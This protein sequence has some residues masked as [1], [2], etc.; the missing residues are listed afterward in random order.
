ML[1]LTG[2]LLGGMLA[3]PTPT[4]PDPA[5]AKR[6]DA[7]L[8]T[9]VAE[10]RIVG[11]VVLVAR[12]GQVVYRRAVGQ[13]D[14]EAGTPMTPDT[15]FR[16][17]SM[18]KP[19]V[20]L[21]ALRLAEQGKLELQA[22]VT[23]YLPWF[24]PRLADGTAPAIT[25]AQLL[26]HS[27]GL[28]YRFE[29]P[30]DGVYARLGISDGLDDAG[31]GLED[32][33]KRLAQA[34]L[35]FPPGQGWRYSLG[36]DVIGAVIEQATGKPLPEAV[37][38]LV[39]GP[40]RLDYLAFVAAPGTPLAVPYADGHPPLR[41]TENMDVPLPEGLGS[42]VRFSPRRAFDAKAFPSGGA[43]MIGTADDYLRLLE[44]VRTGGGGLLKPAT[45]ADARRDQVGAQAQTQGPGW[46]F[47]YGWAVLDDPAAAH[48]PQG[49]GT[50]QWGGAYG[51]NWFVDPAN[52]LSV[53]LLT[54]TAFEGMYG[55]LV[56]QVR[57][58]VY[59]RTVPSSQP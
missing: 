58:A 43:G 38:A 6:L 18:T 40:L 47:G 16:L 4:S 51:H 12:D 36:I 10:Q 2:L 24:R 31:L 55:P 39:T 22:P 34:P 33:L 29:E 27:A 44:F 52:R 13:A 11:A 26:T 48:S 23:R 25:L 42:A 56:G 8:D 19:V 30:A 59:G 32:N 1:A 21:A 9:A 45:L 57:D 14:R 50:L 28:G 46:G 17:A 53:I 7:V 3:I 37:H 49:E 15:P 41:V 5:L 20:T 35:Y 54:D